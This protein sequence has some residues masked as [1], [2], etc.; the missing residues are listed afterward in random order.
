MTSRNDRLTQ[1]YLLR[2]LFKGPWRRIPNYLAGRYL[3]KLLDS[4]AF[5]PYH[6]DIEVT[7]NCN[8]KCTYCV[9][10]LMG[11]SRPKNLTQS[12]FCKIIDSLPNLVSVKLQGRGETFL[13]TDLLD[14]V[15]YLVKKR[16]MVFT[17]TNGTLLNEELCQRI[18]DTGMY[19]VNFSLDGNKESHN[20]VRIGSDYEKIIANMRHLVHL[21]GRRTFPLIR[22]WCVV[23]QSNYRG[24][25]ELIEISHD[26]GVDKVTLQTHIYAQQFQEIRNKLAV[27]RKEQLAHIAKARSRADELGLELEVYSDYGTD[28]LWPWTSAFLTCDGYVLPCCLIES[29]ELIQMGNVR[30]QSFSSIWKSA[31]YR[32]FR[33]KMKSRNY[34]EVCAGC[35][36]TQ[37]VDSSVD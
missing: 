29:P 31:Q 22:V 27:D 19:A 30:N 10:P 23:S 9:V 37:T 34:P 13:N 7:A 25:S 21:R 17:Y 33:T 18:I 11:K 15:E 8:L 6:M 26:L 5:Q 4:G 36:K 16:V 2:S 20:A 35:P 24:L 32:D 3:P 14:M 1:R 28:C 12:E